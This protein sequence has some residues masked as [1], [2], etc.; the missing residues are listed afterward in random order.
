MFV[1]QSFNAWRWGKKII[2]HKFPSARLRC[3][4]ISQERSAVA[5][6]VAHSLFVLLSVLQSMQR[7]SGMGRTRSSVRASRSGLWTCWRTSEAQG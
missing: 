7:T 3:A 4:R 6:C 2:S 5:A 1:R